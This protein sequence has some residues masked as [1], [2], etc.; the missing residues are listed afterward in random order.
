M[1]HNSAECKLCRSSEKRSRERES[2]EIEA[3]GL[4]AWPPQDPGRFS[5]SNNHPLQHHD[6]ATLRGRTLEVLLL[7]SN[8]KITQLSHSA[9][10]AVLTPFLTP[11]TPAATTIGR[12]DL[13]RVL[14]F[15]R[16]CHSSISHISSYCHAGIF[17]FSRRLGL[18]TPASCQI[19]QIFDTAYQS[20]GSGHL[21][22]Y[23]R[24]RKCGRSYTDR[25]KMAANG[26]S[27]HREGEE[28]L[29]Y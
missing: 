6:I 2:G 12:G 7:G 17:T 11:S 10:A 27:S 23:H 19:H 13:H 26:H 22:A 25:S 3:G 20:E 15:L 29:I 16:H 8:V 28:K 24:F 1:S 5:N 21:C 14:P 9:P 4:P 18:K